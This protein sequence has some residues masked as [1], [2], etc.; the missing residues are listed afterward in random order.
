MAPFASGSPSVNTKENTECQE[1]NFEAEANNLL[2]E[3]KSLS[4]KL[5]TDADTLESYKWQTQLS[6]Q[7]H[8]DQLN[9]A[10]EQINAIGQRLHRLQAIKSDVATWQR[11]AIEQIVPVA[12]NVAAHTESAIQHLN[13][14]RTYL[15]APTYSDHLTS[16]A[17][18]SRELK[19]SADLFLEFGDTSD[20]LDR[21]Q[22]RIGLSE[23]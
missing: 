9:K 1:W 14:N 6:W 7:T 17:D 10:R 15:F 4:G 16:I 18:G 13:E 8:A 3:I 2:K 22:E 11:Q 5:N 23:S 19:E 12:A 21:L 20:K